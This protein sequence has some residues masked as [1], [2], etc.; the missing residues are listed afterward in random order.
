[1]FFKKQ[2][3]SIHFLNMLIEPFSLFFAYASEMYIGKV[4]QMIEEEMHFQTHITT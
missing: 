2:G 4:I 3:M 1:M